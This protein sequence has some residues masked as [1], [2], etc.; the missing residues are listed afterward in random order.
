[1]QAR[2]YQRFRGSVDAP[3][4]LSWFATFA[5]REKELHD[6]EAE[7]AEKEKSLLAL[8]GFQDPSG[9]VALRW[10]SLVE[11]R[12]QSTARWAMLQARP[13]NSL[14]RLLRRRR[15][16]PHCPADRPAVGRVPIALG[17]AMPF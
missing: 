9:V 2:S 13:T 16:F 14:R 1:M 4:E 17:G 5:V 3:A 12:K 15:A 10:A 11:Q 8:A 7:L 6:L